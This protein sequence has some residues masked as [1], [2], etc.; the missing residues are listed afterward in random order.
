MANALAAA[1]VL[2]EPMSINGSATAGKPCCVNWCTQA[3]ASGSGRVTMMRGVAKGGCLSV[4]DVAQLLLCWG[5]RV[6]NFK[7][8]TGAVTAGAL[9]FQLLSHRS[10]QHAGPL[11]IVYE[12]CALG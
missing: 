9:R 10:A 8:S 5:Y 12:A 11:N 3:L 6:G 2:H 7:R 4:N 1:G